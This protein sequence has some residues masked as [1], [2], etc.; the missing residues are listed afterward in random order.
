[1]PKKTKLAKGRLDKY[2]WLAKEQGYKSRAAFKL[3]QIDKK[4]KFLSKAKCCLDLCAAPGGWTQVVAKYMPLQS[5]IVAIDID[6]MTSIGGCQC[7]QGDITSKKTEAAVKR[8]LNDWKADIVLNDGSPNVGG[9]WSKDAYGQCELS[10]Y[11]LRMATKFLRK[12][13]V[14]VTKVFRSADYNS[15]LWVCKQLFKTVTPFKP[16]SSRMSSAETFFVCEGYLAPDKIDKRLLDPTFVFKE[17]ENRPP[18]NVLSKNYGKKG[19]RDGYREDITTRATFYETVPIKQF[20]SSER[21]VEFLGRYSAFTFNKDDTFL[22]DNSNID[23][24]EWCADLKLLSKG[25]FRNLLKWR[26]KMKKLLQEEKEEK[27]DLNQPEVEEEEEKI[28]PEVALEQKLNLG[29]KELKEKQRKEKKKR[30]RRKLEAKRRLA[31]IENPILDEGDPDIFSATKTIKSKELLDSVLDGEYAS[32]VESDF[33]SESEVLSDFEALERDLDLMYDEFL[34]KKGKKKKLR[35]KDMGLHEEKIDIEKMEDQVEKE[36]VLK[37]KMKDNERPKDKADRWFSQGA[38]DEIEQSDEEA[39]DEAEEE[40]NHENN[41][42]EKEMEIEKSKNAN[43]KKKTAQEI[44]QEELEKFPGVNPE[45]SYKQQRQK[46]RDN[47]SRRKRLRQEEEK[48]KV[49]TMFFEEASEEEDWSSEDSDAMAEVLA[50]GKKMLNK[51]ERRKLVDKSYNRYA[52]DDP[53]GLPLWFLDDEKKHTQ[54]NLPVT[55]AEVQEH[56]L[57]LKAI[58]ARPLKKVAEAKARKKRRVMKAWESM[59]RKASNIAESIELTE[60]Q[61]S[62]AINKMYK[63][64]D[65]TTNAPQKKRV[66]VTQK[67]GTRT[68]KKSKKMEGGPTN[69]VDRRMKKDLRRDKMKKYGR[70][71]KN[72]NKG[73]GSAKRRKTSN[74][75]KPSKKQ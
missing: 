26:L 64:L 44:V 50:L 23:I 17:V 22:F 54:P 43:E 55:K 45:V 57:Y 46:K 53:D 63:K 40:N 9:A 25:D 24:Q 32:P 41:E 49:E 19:N 62:K 37:Y 60:R 4:F 20:I 8:L 69:R 11:A 38:F 68:A 61:K 67:G 74:R 39:D 2:Y 15:L 5:L 58:N 31:S 70:K 72:S 13:G 12:D 56:K 29:I 35:G 3:I 30:R 33:E 18:I 14:F 34:T 16:P 71:R 59:K 51:K 42:E 7:I 28:D 10:L 52:F 27:E 21:P 75:R 48:K 6:K 36:S 66:L 73:A 47:A 65:R 1:M